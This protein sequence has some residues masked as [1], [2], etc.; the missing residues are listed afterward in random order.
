MRNVLS[1]LRRATGASI[2][3]EADCIVL[4]DRLWCD[5][6]EFVLAA[7]RVLGAV[8][9]T[10]AHRRLALH[11]QRLWQGPPLEPWRYEPWA[12]GLRERAFGLQKKLWAALAALP[13][14]DHTPGAPAELSPLPELGPDG[15][16]SL[17]RYRPGP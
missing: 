16:E 11:A 12:A 10:P 4:G 6:E 14:V 5:L 9:P 2:A 8:D 13:A 7:T 15:R 3:R 17:D 1:S